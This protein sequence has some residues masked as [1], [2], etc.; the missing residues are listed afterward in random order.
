MTDAPKTHGKLR[1]SL[2]KNKS[3][4]VL[5][6]DPTLHFAPPGARDEPLHP[7]VLLRSVSPVSMFDFIRVAG[8]PGRPLLLD[9]GQGPL[10]ASAAAFISHGNSRLRHPTSAL[11]EGP[12]QGWTPEFTRVIEELSATPTDDEF[13]YALCQFIMESK[14][15]LFD[16]VSCY[17]TI[18]IYSLLASLRHESMIDLASRCQL[19]S[20]FLHPPFSLLPCH[21]NISR[22][23][24]I[25]R[26]V[27][28]PA[29][30][31]TSIATSF[32]R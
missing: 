19:L 26:A 21:H 4:D 22:P 14:L 31:I 3:E 9:R 2:H 18:S 8:L 24:P 5:M 13:H 1:R 25:C 15:R 10:H 12:A 6:H 11:A 29:F 23:R 27:P 17:F 30:S 7:T 20:Q 28:F 32:W 16:A